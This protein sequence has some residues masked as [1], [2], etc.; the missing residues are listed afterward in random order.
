[1]CVCVTWP[2]GITR[3]GKCTMFVSLYRRMNMLR[4]PRLDF[5]NVNVHKLD[6]FLEPV[7]IRR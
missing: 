5:V 3:R 1:M 2:P 6:M 7:Q 4:T